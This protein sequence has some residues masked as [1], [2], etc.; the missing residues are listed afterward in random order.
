M[1]KG[2]PGREK[3]LYKGQR[4]TEGSS[5]GLEVGVVWTL[6]YPGGNKVTDNSSLSAFCLLS[7]EQGPWACSA[8]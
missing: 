5:A 3:S 8:C 4:G 6:I 7:Q 2:I 1:K